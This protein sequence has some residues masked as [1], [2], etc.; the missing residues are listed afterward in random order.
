MKDLAKELEKAFDE[1]KEIGTVGDVVHLYRLVSGYAEHRL[2]AEEE[3]GRHPDTVEK[4][5]RAASD[6]LG[7]IKAFTD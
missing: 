6:L 5:L 7:K 2:M 3:R 1:A 4:H